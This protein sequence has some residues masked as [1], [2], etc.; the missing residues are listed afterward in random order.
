LG[1]TFPLL[2]RA[3]AHHR[4]NYIYPFPDGNGRGNLSEAALKTFCEWFLKV[5]FCLEVMGQQQF[6]DFRHIAPSERRAI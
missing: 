2:R 3:S 1:V 6:R 5:S 4:L